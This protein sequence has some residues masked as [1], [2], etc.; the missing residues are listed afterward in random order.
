MHSLLL[1]YHG[2]LKIYLIFQFLSFARAFKLR[3]AE[4]KSSIVLY[5][6]RW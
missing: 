1:A 2:L 6:I 5:Y 4:V 3:H